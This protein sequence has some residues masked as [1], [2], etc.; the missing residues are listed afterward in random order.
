MSSTPSASRQALLARLASAGRDLSDAAVMFHTAL[1]AKVGLGASHWKVLGMLERCGPMTAGELSARS[2]LAPASITGIV[3]RLE[4]G[5]WVRRRQDA[6]DARR[7]VVA[8]NPAVLRRDFGRL[9]Q[10]LA[11][12]LQALYGRYSDEQ[13]ELLLQFM[14]EI[15][16]RQKEATLELEAAR[17][18]APKAGR[19]KRSSG[20]GD[21]K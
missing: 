2:G 14:T 16:Q 15:A 17:F 11:R 4:R 10:G 9:F 18:H 7:V 8:L 13:L 20:R 21:R 1:A 12:R 19:T 5:D 3:D 6:Q